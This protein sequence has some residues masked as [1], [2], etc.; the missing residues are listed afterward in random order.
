M[1]LTKGQAQI[2]AD[3][4]TDCIA[5]ALCYEYNWDHDEIELKASNLIGGLECQAKPE[6]P[7]EL[8]EQQ[9]TILEDAITGNTIMARAQDAI[10]GEDYTPQHWAGLCRSL[11]TLIKK[12]QKLGCKLENSWEHYA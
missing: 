2:L 12:L 8:D 9:L 10:D 1:K 11:Q 7:D 6:L 5:E 4:P 3:R